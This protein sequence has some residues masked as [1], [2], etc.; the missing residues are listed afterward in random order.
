MTERPPF[1]TL[2]RW[3]SDPELR[4]QL[5]AALDDYLDQ[6]RLHG[7]VS[8]HLSGLHTIVFRT[9]REEG[10]D[11]FAR[12]VLRGAEEEEKAERPEPW[13]RGWFVG[14]P[15]LRGRTPRSEPGPDEEKP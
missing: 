6:L 12:E 2:E 3:T 11:D 7:I 8:D 9:V 1:L 14:H 4:E 15:M 5:H 10:W 13:P